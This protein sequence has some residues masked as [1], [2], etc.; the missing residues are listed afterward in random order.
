MDALLRHS[1]PA[2]PSAQHQEGC[3]HSLRIPVPERESGAQE[4]RGQAGGFNGK[5]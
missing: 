4:G 1:F 5:A 3:V 2:L